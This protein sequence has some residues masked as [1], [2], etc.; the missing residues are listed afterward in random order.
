LGLGRFSGYVNN[1]G[2]LA[3]GVET[4]LEAAPFRRTEVRASY[5][6]TNSDQF[7]PA[8]G[9]QR[10]YVIPHHL[11]GLNVNQ[12]Y[13]SLTFNF[14][15]NHTGAYLS[16]IFENDFPFRTAILL[17]KGYT[18][19]DLFVSYERALTERLRLILFGG[20][21]NILAQEYFENGFR[22]PGA[23]GR[24]GASFRF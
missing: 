10:E 21:E 19:A 13:R 3:R 1:P 15:L 4:Y 8:L 23:L 14:D 20:A 11:F 16:P 6:Y 18:K 22:A 12:R 7:V 24:G 2:G 9:L 5:T 17:F